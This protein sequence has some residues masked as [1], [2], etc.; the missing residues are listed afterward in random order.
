MVDREHYYFSESDSSP[1]YDGMVGKTFSGFIPGFAIKYRANF[2]LSEKT[3]IG[4]SIEYKYY[5][6]SSI[7]S[8]WNANKD[9][10]S[11]LSGVKYI[12]IDESGTLG[13]MSYRHASATDTD[14]WA[15]QNKTHYWYFFEFEPETYYW[16]GNS[17][18]DTL[19]C[20]I[21]IV[22]QL[23]DTLIYENFPYD[24]NTPFSVLKDSSSSVSKEDGNFV[25]ELERIDNY[26]GASFLGKDVSGTLGRK[27]LRETSTS[28]DL[29]IESLESNKYYWYYFMF[30]TGTYYYEIVGGSDNINTNAILGVVKELPVTIQEF[31]DFVL[32]DYMPYTLLS[33][34]SNDEPIR[35]ATI[36]TPYNDNSYLEHVLQENG[37]YLISKKNNA[38]DILD[39]HYLVQTI[40]YDGS[41]LEMITDM[42]GNITSETE[43]N[44]FGVEVRKSEKNNLNNL[45]V[46]TYETTSSGVL[47]GGFTEEIKDDDNNT[48]KLTRNEVIYSRGVMHFSTISGLASITNYEIPPNAWTYSG[49][50]WFPSSSANVSRDGYFMFH[51]T[52]GN[53]YI[54]GNNPGHVLIRN[55]SGLSDSGGTGDFW[56]TTDTWHHFARVYTP[57]DA[58]TTHTSSRRW[59]FK[60]YL[61]GVLKKEVASGTLSNYDGNTSTYTCAININ[62]EYN[63]FSTSTM[64]PHAFVK[65]SNYAIWNNKGLS[66]SEMQTLH[67]LGHLGEHSLY[68]QASHLWTFGKTLQDINGTGIQFEITWRD[69]DT[70]QVLKSTEFPFENRISFE[71]VEFGQ[72]NTFITEY[73]LPDSENKFTEKT[74]LED[75]TGLLEVKQTTNVY[76]AYENFS[77]FPPIS[78]FYN[79]MTSIYGK[80]FYTYNLQ[81]G[82]KVHIRKHDP[83]VSVLKIDN[84]Q[85]FS[86][87]QIYAKSGFKPPDYEFTYS[88]W[89]Y[90]TEAGGNCTVFLDGG[91][92]GIRIR[93]NNTTTYTIFIDAQAYA[94]ASTTANYNEWVLIT[95]VSDKYG[96]YAKCYKNDTYFGGG[97]DHWGR[98]YENTSYFG[99]NYSA[100]DTALALHAV[101]LKTTKGNY[102]AYADW[103]WT[104]S[105]MVIANSSSNYINGKFCKFALWHSPLTIE[106][107]TE[108]YGLGI[109]WTLTSSLYS[110]MDIYSFWSFENTLVDNVNGKNFSG[111]AQYETIGTAVELSHQYKP[112]YLFDTVYDRTTFTN[113]YGY[114]ADNANDIW[115]HCWR[116]H[117]KDE[118]IVYEFQTTC[119]VDKMT[120]V[121]SP[122]KYFT[123]D[124]EILYDDGTQF[125]TVSNQ[126]YNGFRYKP[127]DWGSQVS[128]FFDE[129]TSSR[130][131]IKPTNND[132]YCALSEWK[133]FGYSTLQSYIVSAPDSSGNYTET[134]TNADGSQTRIQK[135]INSDTQLSTTTIY[136]PDTAGNTLY[137]ETFADSST[138]LTT[139][140]SDGVDIL[141]IETSIPDNDGNTVKTI[142]TEDKSVEKKYINENN[143]IY[144]VEH[145]DDEGV[146]TDINGNYT[147]EVVDG[148]TIT[149]TSSD[150]IG[151]PL[152]VKTKEEVDGVITTTVNNYSYTI[153]YEN[154]IPVLNDTNYTSY[155][156]ENI[157]DTSIW[158][159]FDNDDSTFM[160]IPSNSF[161]NMVIDLQTSTVLTEIVIKKK[162]D[163]SGKDIR[164][165]DFEFSEDNITYSSPL[166][167]DFSPSSMVSTDAMV[168]YDAFRENAI[169][170]SVLTDFSG[171]NRHATITGGLN[172]VDYGFEFTGTNFVHVNG[173]G[174][175]G[176]NWHH[177]ISIW[178]TIDDW[179]IPQ[180][181]TQQRQDPFYI[182]T[183]DTGKGSAIDLKNSDI[184]WYFYAVDAGRFSNPGITANTWF[185]LCLVYDSS[186]TKYFY[187]NGEL[188]FQVS[189]SGSNS[190]D[191]DTPLWLGL[192]GPRNTSKFSGKIRQFSVYDRVFTE[193]EVLQNYNTGIYPILATIRT[194]DDIKTRY[195]RLSGVNEGHVDTTVLS[196]LKIIKKVYNQIITLASVSTE[197][198]VDGTIHRSITKYEETITLENAIL[199]LT[200]TNYTQYLSNI[201]EVWGEYYIFQI[202]DQD[203]TTPI[204]V[205]AT[206]F[207]NVLLDLQSNMEL[208]EIRIVKHSDTAGRTVKTLTIEFSTDNVNFGNSITWNDTDSTT[209]QLDKINARYARI[210]GVNNGHVDS[211]TL[212]EL[213]FYKNVYST[214]TLTPE[215]QSI[216]VPDLDGNTVETIVDDENNTS[217]LLKRNDN[218]IVIETTDIITSEPIIKNTNTFTVQWTNPVSI[219][220]SIKTLVNQQTST[221][222]ENNTYKYLTVNTGDTI[223]FNVVAGHELYASTYD[224]DT[225]T[226]TRT[227]IVSPY[228]IIFDTV[229]TYGF[230]CFASH[231]SMILVVNVALETVITETIRNLEEG[232]QQVIL[233]D[234]ETNVIL[235]TTTY[236]KPDTSGLYSGN[237]YGSDGLTKIAT[238]S[239]SFEDEYIKET[240]LNTDNS[241]ITILKNED[242]EDL[243]IST[244]DTDGNLIDEIEIGLKQMLRENALVIFNPVA[245]NVIQGSLVKDKSG[246]NRDAQISGNI[247]IHDN[248]F[249]LDGNSYL[250]VSDIGNPAG[251][252]KHSISCWFYFDELP[253]AYS[254]PFFIGLNSTNKCSSCQIELNTSAPVYA[255]SRAVYSV[256]LHWYY[257][258]NDVTFYPD[259]RPRAWY[260]ICFVYDNDNNKHLYVNGTLFGPQVNY[261]GTI[262]SPSPLNINAN[263]YLSLGYDGRRNEHNMTGRIGQFAIYDSILTPEEVKI[264]YEAG[265]YVYLKPIKLKDTL[266]YDLVHSIRYGNGGIEGLST[267]SSTSLENSNVSYIQET[268]FGTNMYVGSYIYPTRHA[269][270]FAA[271]DTNWKLEIVFNKNST[272]S[273]ARTSIF[274][275]SNP[276]Q[277][278]LFR[279]YTS[280][281]NAWLL[282]G[283]PIAS[284]VAFG[285]HANESFI[286]T[287]NPIQPGLNPPYNQWGKWTLVFNK[288]K[289]RVEL[290][291]NDEPLILTT[292]NDS[293]STL[294]EGLSTIWE[295][296]F[297]ISEGFFTDTLECK[298]GWADQGTMT[299]PTK[300]ASFDISQDSYSPHIFKY[301]VPESQ[302]TYNAHHST[303]NKST[304]SSTSSWSDESAKTGGWI[305]MDLGNLETVHG[306]YTI[307]RAPTNSNQHVTRIKVETSE[308]DYTWTIALENVAANYDNINGV[309]NYF[310]NSITTR[311]V[312]I[313]VLSYANHPSLRAAV[314]LTQ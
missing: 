126:S 169:N 27:T 236:T 201:P 216:S 102:S 35:F 267:F 44:P 186:N 6:D 312:K 136:L 10:L 63:R 125:T 106:Q 103:A 191:P 132:A 237:V 178:M 209:I 147:N 39:S 205:K 232:T 296:T 287:N 199:P 228:T 179:P 220:G 230:N 167:I 173:I 291:Y 263:E 249:I 123:T 43:I 95:F 37:S 256:K 292:N 213:T 13:R 184:D 100:R 112:T 272:S 307:G 198:E 66:A 16:D 190:L 208:G 160:E 34:D 133:F 295:N 255:G 175:P 189:S 262:Q 78:Q 61:D 176:G 168:I 14:V 76:Y 21:G 283:T 207:T 217:T 248:S 165:L 69:A 38:G 140:N 148:N 98:Y 244:Y 3:I 62:H 159:I 306:V 109:G 94:E 303:L 90:I 218:D 177:T 294:Y 18:G 204:A 193:E 74:P 58:G 273:T 92:N 180:T 158:K 33:L 300:I 84:K 153:T 86:T 257:Y 143:F 172:V 245:K 196:E 222:F 28:N 265:K 285:Y 131:M 111:T 25:K 80:S 1:Y 93:P 22:K 238:V 124:I 83:P 270:N 308:D 113:Q 99:T 129:T 301:D 195:I 224:G 31:S 4:F 215:T 156:I 118:E 36:S 188:K 81:N 223:N 53:Y 151:L 247:Q 47:T 134:G 161:S 253:L 162:G 274:S 246:F 219:D 138:K 200:A 154:A 97:R 73:T 87:P 185:H 261:Y 163:G 56:M 15:A 114:N 12:G 65:V 77:L 275:L 104:T 70:N 304:L 145:F 289:L 11:S 225:D 212:N 251:N 239:T 88:G 279:V 24:V 46:T 72:F 242:G 30:D 226:I 305:K 107:I 314:L 29:L 54:L 59:N 7:V 202:F 234:P 64:T 117:F 170:G 206:G 243:V 68:T 311:Y 264:N 211:T 85:Y 269:L 5:I 89:F 297:T 281:G 116:G 17:Y 221:Y 130:F 121:N 288:R 101:S 141:I 157:P 139:T 192:D 52:L 146:E 150:K 268:V 286:A 55:Y 144:N 105:K 32:I 110:S 293:L 50:I 197:E 2:T 227:D 40:L 252:W 231:A 23:P 48:L 75:N 67:S 174:N 241:S 277:S 194:L 19:I 26:Q 8:A 284:E 259:I 108:L 60:M 142:T 182:G 282:W 271:P 115:K 45:V 229:G 183:N 51:S 260:H 233:K 41:T 254:R 149:T 49:W 79:Q 250:H 258:G 203:E 181:S 280:G 310:D 20:T 71:E 164:T 82:D 57:I 240:R 171:N 290:F 42:E 214:N 137:S 278:C 135:N 276:T 122:N 309:F 155:L 119:T 120:F 302:R 235:E 166:E 127:N 266:A 298:I 313:T 152:I 96:N 210:S 187:I 128:I 91:R 299:E 9:R